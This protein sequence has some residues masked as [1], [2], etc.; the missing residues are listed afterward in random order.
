[1]PLGRKFVPERFMR[2]SEAS[3]EEGG[4]GSRYSYRLRW[5]S[6]LPDTFDNNARVLLGL[7]MPHDAIISDRAF[8]TR[9]MIDSFLGYPGAVTAVAYD[10]SAAPLK[11]TVILSTQGP[12]KGPLPPRRIEI[13]INALRSEAEGDAVFRT[14]ELARQVFVGPQEAQVYDYD[15]LNQYTLEGPGKVSGRQ[16][17]LLYLQPQDQLYFQSGGRAV[18]AHEFTYEMTRLPVP[19]DAPR[20]AVACVDTPKFVAQCI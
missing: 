15:I 14:S 17:Y 12:D 8:N 19:V 1:M 16:R 3:P 20:G 6:T 18:A 9:S 4:P 5:Y 7:G 11:E 10:P 13:Y 2:E